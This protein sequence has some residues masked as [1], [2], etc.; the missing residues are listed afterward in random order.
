M[1]KHVCFILKEHQDVYCE[2]LNYLKNCVTQDFY[3]QIKKSYSQ[4]NEKQG[5]AS[6]KLL[7]DTLNF[8]DKI[9]Y[10]ISSNLALSM[11]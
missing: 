2:L 8:W 9:K 7:I 1:K 4:F 11:E 6:E 5:K 3:Y 10:H